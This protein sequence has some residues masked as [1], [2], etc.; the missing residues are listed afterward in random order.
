[1]KEYKK[2]FVINGCN[3]SEKDFNRILEYFS[4]TDIFPDNLEVDCSSW[5]SKN[6]VCQKI[7]G[8]KVYINTYYFNF[9]GKFIEIGQSI[10]SYKL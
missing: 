7:V 8:F 5:V 10:V 2:M 1:M 3:V 4:T 9:F 6:T